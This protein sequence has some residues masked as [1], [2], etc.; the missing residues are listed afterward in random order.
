MLSSN[1]VRTAWA[2]DDRLRIS[3]RVTGAVYGEASRILSD[4]DIAFLIIRRSSRMLPLNVAKMS[5][6]NETRGMHS[7]RLSEGTRHDR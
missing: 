6:G 1:G 5:A 2:Y 3:N 7:W 4:T